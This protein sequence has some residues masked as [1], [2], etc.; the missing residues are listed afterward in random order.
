[1]SFFGIIICLILNCDIKLIVFL[2]FSVT[3]VEHSSAQECTDINGFRR[4]RQLQWD[5]RLNTCIRSLH[6]A[7]CTT[8]VNTCSGTCIPTAFRAPSS[9]INQQ[10]IIQVIRREDYKW[11]KYITKC[12]SG[13]CR[14]SCKSTTICGTLL[15]CV[16]RNSS[17]KM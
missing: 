12:T 11:N 4:Q 7:D 2:W 16:S 17:L 5:K 9:C 15:R 14:G 6:I 8:L 3:F 10:A 13:S 1:M